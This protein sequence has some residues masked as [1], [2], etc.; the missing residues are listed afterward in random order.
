[1]VQSETN[2]RF[3]TENT[4][5]AAYLVSVGISEPEVERTPKGVHFLFTDGNIDIQPFVNKWLAG[6]STGNIPLFYRNYKRFLRIVNN[7]R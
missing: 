6:T 2:S 4:A 1:M 5:L 3:E 7:G